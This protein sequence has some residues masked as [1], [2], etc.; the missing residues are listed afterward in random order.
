MEE[1]VQILIY[2]EMKMNDILNIV[3]LIFFYNYGYFYFWK[4]F[5]IRYRLMQLN[6][7]IKQI[8]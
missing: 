3:G 6:V 1:K 4:D 8:F 2:K 7:Y 5:L